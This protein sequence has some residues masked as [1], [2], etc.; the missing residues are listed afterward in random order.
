MARSQ[1]HHKVSRNSNAVVRKLESGNGNIKGMTCLLPLENE[2][3]VPVKVIGISFHGYASN[4]VAVLVSPDGGYG[5]LS[6]G[7]TELLDD[8]PAARALY[9]AK[10]KAAN[11]LRDHQPRDGATDKQ[12]REAVCRERAS[13]TDAQRKAFDA[14]APKRFR[15]NVDM[16]AGIKEASNY[17]LKDLFVSA[18][19]IRFGCDGDV[20]EDD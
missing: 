17:T 15:E 2:A 19:A 10:A 7:A 3:L 11:Y 16:L 20:S 12:W 6:V 8:T 5:S 1:T 9:T 4:G 18:V 13:M 14:T